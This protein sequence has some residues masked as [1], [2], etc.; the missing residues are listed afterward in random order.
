MINYK[1]KL[2]YNNILVKFFIIFIFIFKLFL[3]IKKS[4]SD[5]FLSIFMKISFKLNFKVKKLKI[6]KEN[7]YLYLIIYFTTKTW[8]L[9][10]L[11][12]LSVTL[13]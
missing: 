7:N 13:P 3:N 8:H 6:R 12:T 9:A 2:N 5:N 1:E 11:T 10:D 4:N